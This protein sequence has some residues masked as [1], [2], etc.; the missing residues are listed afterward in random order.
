MGSGGLGVVSEMGPE[1][2]AH[3]LE[4]SDFLDG[5]WHRSLSQGFEVVFRRGDTF[6]GEQET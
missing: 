4:L 1:E 5:G 6:R 2:V 3:A